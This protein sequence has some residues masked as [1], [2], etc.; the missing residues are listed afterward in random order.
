VQ[1]RQ[2]VDSTEQALERTRKTLNETRGEQ[3]RVRRNMDSVSDTTA[4]DD[5]LFRKLVAR[6]NEIES[7]RDQV[8]ELREERNRRRNRLSEYL[9]TLTID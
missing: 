9:R 2:A 5:R 4:F 6:E 8:D 7:L 3:S 1:L